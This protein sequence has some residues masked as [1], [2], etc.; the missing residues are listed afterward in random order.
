VTRFVAFWQYF[1]D[2]GLPQGVQQRQAPHFDNHSKVPS[3]QLFNIRNKLGV[4][5][6]W[7]ARK[8]IKRAKILLT[9]FGVSKYSNNILTKKAKVKHFFCAARFF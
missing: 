1:K 8:L 5:K 9:P 4:C 6:Y 2:L 7:L 3:L